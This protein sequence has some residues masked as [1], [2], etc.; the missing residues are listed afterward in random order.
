MDLCVTRQVRK[1]R[2]ALRLHVGSELVLVPFWL[3][4]KCFLFRCV[5]ARG[6]T[7]ES[8]QELLI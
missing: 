4:L 8:R 2:R 6:S 1:R 5:M 7:A 3:G